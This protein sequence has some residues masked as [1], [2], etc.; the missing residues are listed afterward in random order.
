MLDIS[1]PS[2]CLLNRFIRAKVSMRAAVVFHRLGPYH[3]AR[4]CATSELCEITAIEM[5]AETLEYAWSK[6]EPSESYKRVTL[7]PEGES[8]GRSPKEVMARTRSALSDC[9][10]EV[11]AIPGWSNNGAFAALRWCAETATPAVLMSES[12]AL[13][14]PRVGWRERIKRRIVRL[15]STALVGGQSH[16]RYLEELGMPSDRIF[17]GYDAVDNDYFARSAKEVRSKKEELRKKFELPESYF[18]ASARFIEKKNLFRLLK[19]Y[20]E[21]RKQTEVESRKE[22]V[23]VWDLVLLG[24]GPLRE[25]L[26]SELCKSGL[27]F[28]C[29]T[30]ALDLRDHV[31]LPGFKQY[32]E[33]P[34]Y[35]G[36]ASA[37]VHASTTE[38]W[39][40]VVNEAMASG[41]P[42]LVSNRCGCAPDLVQE[43]RNGFAFDPENIEQ[44]AGLMLKMATAPSRLPAMGEAS[45]DIIAQ[46][47]PERF[48]HG[49]EAAARAAIE[50]GPR[51]MGLLDSMLLELL[52]RR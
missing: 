44:L 16:Q 2:G 27:A 52:I 37:F 14:E 17:L 42:V 11:V 45:Q 7:F 28:G 51:R 49:W 32:D 15:F 24:D 18:L 26:N 23:E 13:D 9:Q 47:G 46:W 20:S 19:A 12:T 3:G 35:Y 10:P 33:L 38:Q 21:Y 8:R 36:L 5:A 22:K 48:A 50:A 6:V 40:L 30:A 1:R 43:G 34:T 39:G 29:V 41:L 25:S 4:L 31:H